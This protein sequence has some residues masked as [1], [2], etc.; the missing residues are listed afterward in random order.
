MT[1]QNGFRTPCGWY[2]LL[3]V[4]GKF[5]EDKHYPDSMIIA[6]IKANLGL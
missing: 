5:D 6:I 2:G 1:N 4:R 3:V